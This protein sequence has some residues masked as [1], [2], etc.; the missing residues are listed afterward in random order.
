MSGL[1][2][3]DETQVF[4]YTVHALYLYPQVPNSVPFFLFVIIYS[5]P[6]YLFT[7]E[8]GILPYSP[9]GLEFTATCLIVPSVGIIGKY[10]HAWS[11][12]R[13]RNEAGYSDQRTLLGR[14]TPMLP[15]IFLPEHL[16]VLYLKINVN[17][18]PNKFQLC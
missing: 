14:S 2:D 7:F 13:S 3:E 9:A 18:S 5:M 1:S 8:I 11:H 12:I 4:M 15:Y 10:R 16:S 17:T 6:G